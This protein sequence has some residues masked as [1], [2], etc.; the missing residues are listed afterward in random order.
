MSQFDPTGIEKLAVVADRG[1]FSSEE[2]F[3]CEQAC[4]VAYVPKPLTSG[5]KA[6]GR[7]GKQNF[8]YM[9]GRDEYHCPAGH[10]MTRRFE[11]VDK[12]LVINVHATPSVD[13]ACASPTVQPAR[14]AASDVGIMKTSLTPCRNGSARRLSRSAC[15]GKPWSIHSAPLN[16][17]WMPRAT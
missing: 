17:G 13:A 16:H 1:Y 9:P 2:V 8:V 10:A 7:F 12:G 4:I 14:S 3:A 11:T 15:D 5:A 6:D